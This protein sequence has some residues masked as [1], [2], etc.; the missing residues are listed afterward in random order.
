MSYSYDGIHFANDSNKAVTVQIVDDNFPAVIDNPFVKG[1]NIDPHNDPRQVDL[2]VQ[3]IDQT[4]I[5]GQFEIYVN[6]QDIG[7]VVRRGP[8]AWDLYTLPSNQIDLVTGDPDN[9]DIHWDGTKLTNL[10]VE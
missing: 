5:T 2:V 6:G 7:Y 9:V 1:V 4:L 10:T 8:D 3:D